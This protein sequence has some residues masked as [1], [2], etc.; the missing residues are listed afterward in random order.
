ME[1]LLKSSSGRREE[2]RYPLQTRPS[3][4]SAVGLTAGPATTTRSRA[5]GALRGEYVAPKPSDLYDLHYQLSDEIMPLRGTNEKEL[6]HGLNDRFAAFIDKVRH[7]E[8]QNTALEKE[9]EAVRL[10]AK[11]SAALSREYEPEMKELRDQVREMSVQKQQVELSLQSLQDE[12]DTLRERCEQ[13]ARQRA[14]VEDSVRVLK[15]FIGDAQL[16]KQEMDRKAKALEDEIGFLK[17]NHEDEVAEIAANIQESQVRQEVSSFGR[18]DLT[19]ALRDIR[20]QLEGHAAVCDIQPADERFRVH[21]AQLT[22][23]AEI[24]RETL[25]V[26]KAEI[27]DY[28]RQLQ[29]KSVELDSVKGM[30][31]ALERQLFDLEQRHKAELHHYQVSLHLHCREYGGLG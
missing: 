19:A 7:L 30:R 29:S 1:R 16:A 12:L 31:E 2:Q 18:V 14:G 20:L 17:K 15:K 9:I 5:T 26:T 6:L 10:R 24:N 23:A 21:V 3:R 13:E 4:A 22:R 11:S 28:R 25:L 27:S 8:S